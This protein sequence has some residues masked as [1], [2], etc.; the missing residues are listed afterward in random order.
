[1]QTIQ[2]KD[3]WRW[4]PTYMSTVLRQLEPVVKTESNYASL[5]FQKKIEI[6]MQL[7]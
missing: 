6:L 2:H 4:N 7:Y 3:M 5:S 1:M